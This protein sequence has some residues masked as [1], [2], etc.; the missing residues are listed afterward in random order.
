MINVSLDRYR[1]VDVQLDERGLKRRL[2]REG[3]ERTEGWLYIKLSEGKNR[4]IRKMLRP[5]GLIV[6]RLVRTHYGPWKLKG[7]SSGDVQE[8]RFRDRQLA[9]WGWDGDGSNLRI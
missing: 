3:K 7:L 9:K 6:N 2:R 1:S 5:V 8:V 4:E